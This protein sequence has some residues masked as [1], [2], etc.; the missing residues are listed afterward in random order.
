VEPYLGEVEGVVGTGGRIFLR[1][2]LDKHGPAGEI[3]LFD[4]LIQVALVAFP[5]LADNCF[6]L[7]ICQIA[8][9]LLRF[10]VKLDPVAFVF[11]VDKAESV[12][13]V[14]TMVT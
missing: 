14:M 5:A 4:A 7:C 8:D 3:T 13:P 9:S 2:H 6:G 10:E 1:H 12:A 11:L